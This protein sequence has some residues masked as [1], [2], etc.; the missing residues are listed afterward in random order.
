MIS[1]YT[2][3]EIDSPKWPCR[4]NKNGRYKTSVV[5]LRFIDISTSAMSVIFLSGI[6]WQFQVRVYVN[7]LSWLIRMIEYRVIALGRYIIWNTSPCSYSGIHNV[8]AILIYCSH[9]GYGR[10]NSISFK[11]APNF[12]FITFRC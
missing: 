7:T 10:R 12:S 1:L 11:S 4:K 5:E 9:H 2:S 6:N 8:R 3:V